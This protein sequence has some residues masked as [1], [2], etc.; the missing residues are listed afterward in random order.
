MSSLYHCADRDQ[1]LTGMRLS[2][3]AL[4]NGELVVFP[5]DTVY[6]IAADAFN[7][8]AV[9][10][11]L[12]AKARERSS[13]PPVLVSGY[14]TFVALVECVPEP[15]EKLARL[16][17]PGGLT[18]ILPAAR[19]LSWDLGHTQGTV[20]IRVPDAKIAQELLTETGPLAVSS[21]N[22]TGE[23]PVRTAQQAQEVFGEKVAV[24]L[25]QED[26]VLSCSFEEHLQQNVST[27]IDATA[28]VS[29]TGKI[30]VLRQ[31]FVSCET[32]YSIVPQHF[33]EPVG[34]GVAT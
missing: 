20:A 24:Y 4:A 6:G 30:R 9:S 2:R 31:G 14:D 11:L 19:S 32:L 18:I 12:E 5:T 17:W 7:P 10:A 15:V 23:P 16:L 34:G 8:K 21:A 25:E 27:I 26:S 28:L 22:I 33:Q 13:P 1:L 3:A 29:K